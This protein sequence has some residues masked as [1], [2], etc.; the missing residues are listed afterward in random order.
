VHNVLSMIH[1]ENVF[2]LGLN[3]SLGEF[4]DRIPQDV[5]SSFAIRSGHLT[6]SGGRGAHVSLKPL[7]DSHK[8][9]H[10]HSREE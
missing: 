5:Y 9:I 2:K 10:W 3:N 1:D 7:S 6:A 8:V 4:V